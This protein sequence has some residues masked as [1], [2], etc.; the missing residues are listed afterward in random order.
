MRRHSFELDA[1]EEAALDALPFEHIFAGGML[2]LLRILEDR[3]RAGS[4][5]LFISLKMT[6]RCT[7]HSDVTATADAAIEATAERCVWAAS[8]SSIALISRK[9]SP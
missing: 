5:A 3:R 8:H 1:T 4:A 7:P 9:A 2:A 6:G